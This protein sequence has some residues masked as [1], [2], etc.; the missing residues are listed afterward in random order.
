MRH[1]VLMLSVLINAFAGAWANSESVVNIKNLE[2]SSL[3]ANDIKSGELSA[4]YITNSWSSDALEGA[5]IE[6]KGGKVFDLGNSLKTTSSLSL[7]I[8]SLDDEVSSVN[9]ADQSAVEFSFYQ[10]ISLGFDFSNTGVVVTPFVEGKVSR[11]ELEVDLSNSNTLT[12][13]QLDI[14]YTKLG[15]GA[16]L[17]FV[18]RSGLTPFIKYEVARARL[19]NSADV[20][21]VVDGVTL[22][23]T[24]IGLSPTEQSFN[25][26]TLS[27]G[28]GV[29]F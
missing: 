3:G 29:V 21:T 11:G 19:D 26:S 4:S 9:Q 2:T 17:L 23:D 12:R 24:S 16:G 15:V 10:R 1:T 25:I 13:T 27:I 8:L 7:S 6:L 22:V 5:G 14:G 20:E 28:L 18:T